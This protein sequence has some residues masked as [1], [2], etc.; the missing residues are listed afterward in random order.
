MNEPADEELAV[1]LV[2]DIGTTRQLDVESLLGPKFG[3]GESMMKLMMMRASKTSFSW[4]HYPG[5]TCARGY[6]PFP[7]PTSFRMSSRWA[8]VAL[9]LVLE[10]EQVD[11]AA[12]RSSFLRC[13]GDPPPCPQRRSRV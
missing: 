10:W 1:V 9:L 12:R 6:G 11:L 13:S 2:S 4:K 3:A 8:T 7:S 5:C